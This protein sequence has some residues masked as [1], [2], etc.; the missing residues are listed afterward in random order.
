MTGPLQAMQEAA[1]GGPRGY[2]PT[3]ARNVPDFAEWFSNEGDVPMQKA[4]SLLEELITVEGPA[5]KRPEF[6][7]MSY[8]VWSGEFDDKGK[9]WTQQPGSKYATVSWTY[10]SH[11]P[12][13]Q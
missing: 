4:T 10:D 5:C 7:M 9:H 6:D 2:R 13:G 3:M 8:M 11:A 1:L 12:S